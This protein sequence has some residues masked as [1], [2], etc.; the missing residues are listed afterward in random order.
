MTVSNHLRWSILTLIAVC[1]FGGTDVAQAQGGDTDAVQAE[2]GDKRPVLA[3]SDRPAPSVEITRQATAVAGT[4]TDDCRDTAEF[5]FYTGL[6]IDTFAADELARYLNPNDSGG[7]RERFLAGFDF[8]YRALE[9]RGHQLWLYGETVHGVRSTDVDCAA[10][11]RLASISPP[12]ARTRCSSFAMRRV[13]KPLPACVGNS[14]R[15]TA[16]GIIARGPT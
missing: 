7:T 2:G 10:D 15:S 11:E 12:L 14:R 6:S 13:S 5:S 8:A 4:C 3:A 9:G 1:L 16:A